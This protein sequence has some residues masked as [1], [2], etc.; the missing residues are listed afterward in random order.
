MA[1]NDTTSGFHLLT[2]TLYG[3]YRRRTYRSYTGHQKYRT[4]EFTCVLDADRVAR[5]GH[6]PQPM[7]SVRPVTE[8]V[9][10]RDDDDDR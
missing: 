9:Q 8:A 1:V 2:V 10:E 4:G 5:M 6:G 7:R 3:L